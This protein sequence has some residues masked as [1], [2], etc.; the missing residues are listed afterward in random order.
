MIKKFRNL[1]IGWLGS[2]LIRSIACT[3]RLKVEDDSGIIK[4]PSQPPVIYVFWHNRMFLMPYVYQRFFPS[5]RAACLASASQDGE[6]IARVLEKFGLQTVR[7]SSSRRGREAFREL[8]EEIRTGKDAAITPDG[9]RGPCYSIQPGVLTLSAMSGA[10]LVPMSFH[11]NWRIRLKS[12]D[13]FI[14]PI[15]FSKCVC[16]MGKPIRINGQSSEGDQATLRAELQSELHKLVP[17]E[18]ID[19]NTEPNSEA[20]TRLHA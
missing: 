14:I 4:N 10:P 8:L 17:E 3:L 20:K 12:W 6:M 5:R 19:I 1:L 13:Q 11:A 2:I 18:S 15:P 7:G 16:R 9:P